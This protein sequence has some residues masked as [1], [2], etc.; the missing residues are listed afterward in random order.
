MQ[1]PCLIAQYFSDREKQINVKLK[2]KLTS[3]KVFYKTGWAAEQQKCETDIGVIWTEAAEGSWKVKLL[4]KQ[5]LN[6]SHV[7]TERWRSCQRDEEV[8]EN[9]FTE[10]AC[11]L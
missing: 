10:R 4:K 5:N 1:P 2:V 6:L 11:W 8:E 7:K 9:I 3:L